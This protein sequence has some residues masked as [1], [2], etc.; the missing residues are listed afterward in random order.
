VPKPNS[1][2]EFAATS[3]GALPTLVLAILL[4]WGALVGCQHQPSRS[5]DEAALRELKLQ[6]WP[7]AYREQDLALLDALL[8]EDFVLVEGNG[9]LS[10]KADELRWVR[11]NRPP[12]QDF[13]YVIERL[14]IYGDSALIIGLGTIQRQVDGAQKLTRYRSSNTLIRERGR[15]RALASQVT[16]LPAP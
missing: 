10:N 3:R 4:P 6:L 13:R 14:E 9:Q 11:A 15:W 5:A 1:D 2:R 7:R 8:R 12:E 16:L